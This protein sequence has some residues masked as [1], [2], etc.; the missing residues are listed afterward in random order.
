MKP[1]GKLIDFHSHILPN[2][3]DGSSSVEMSLQ[4]IQTSFQQGVYAIVLTPHFYASKDY[5]DHFFKKRSRLLKELNFR[6]RFPVPLLI[7]GAEVQYFEGITA[8]TELPQ[9]RIE[10]SSGLLIEMPCRAW[11]GRMI[12]DILELNNRAEYQVILAH[13][14]RYLGDQKESVIRKLVEAGILMQSNASFFKGTF[15]KRKALYMLENGMIHLLGSDCHNMTSRPPNLEEACD[16][17]AKKLGTKM[18]KTIMNRGFQVLLKEARNDEIF[19][20][21]DEEFAL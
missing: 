6:R 19:H 14:E 15:S 5:P 13:I 7:A 18:V 10:K 3:D 9:M 11:S 16:V 1:Y 20:S 4:M 8:M 17:I 21:V 12:D 2:M